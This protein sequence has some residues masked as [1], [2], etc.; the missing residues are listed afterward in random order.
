MECLDV[1]S[2]RIRHGIAPSRDTSN[3]EDG[4]EQAKPGYAQ[5]RRKFEA[6][7]LCTRHS[8][9]SKRIRTG[10]NKRLQYRKGTTYDFPSVPRLLGGGAKKTAKEEMQV[11]VHTCSVGPRACTGTDRTSRR[12][13]VA[14]RLLAARRCWPLLPWGAGASEA[15]A[16]KARLDPAGVL[17]NLGSFGDA[18]SYRAD[19]LPSRVCKTVE[20][21]SK[22]CLDT[23]VNEFLFSKE[24]DQPTKQWCPLLPTALPT[25]HGK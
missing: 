3:E 25:A 23:L 8:S 16:L 9:S 17:S 12:Y 10:D 4:G 5:S 18:R 2:N 22:Q 11:H 21:L 14:P 24:V 6:I 7:I 1:G 20:E 19:R 15:S 13:K